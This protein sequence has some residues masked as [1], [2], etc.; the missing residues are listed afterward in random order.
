MDN[1]TKILLAAMIVVGIVMAG[2]K[3]GFLDSLENW[4]SG[5]EKELTKLSNQIEIA[6]DV[7]TKGVAASDQLAAFEAHSLPY[8]PAVAKSHYQAWLLSLVESNSL[9][10]ASV[11]VGVPTSVTI[12]DKASGKTNEIYK[13][14]GFSV[15]GG[16]T[17]EQATRF[18]FD[19]YQGC[20]LQK[21]NT[22]SLTPVGRGR[23]SLS[24][25]GEAIGVSSCERKSD[26]A[27]VA[28]DRL[29]HD[30]FDAYRM[31]LRRNIF[32]KEASVALKQIR[33]TSVTY[34]RAGLPEAWFKVGPQQQTRKLQRGGRLAIAVH[35]IEVIDIQPRSV[36]VS[37]DGTGVVFKVG[38]T[39]HQ[40]MTDPQM[41]ASK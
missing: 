6:T 37:V 16:G 13:R 8:D 22:L 18:L 12:K 41:A 36:L 17:L 3:L 7:I 5:H 21:I 11:D 27:T 29:E 4:G 35:D 19:F 38:T 28:V 39:L 31:I 2:D 40:A 30:D 25:T 23:F 20:H 24:I 9:V 15:S 33:L 1:R 26:M 14:Y 32:S 10:Q 34:D